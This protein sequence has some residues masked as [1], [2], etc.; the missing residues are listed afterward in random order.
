MSFIT[1]LRRAREQASKKDPGSCSS[2]DFAERSGTTASS[3]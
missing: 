2:K 3:G 1:E